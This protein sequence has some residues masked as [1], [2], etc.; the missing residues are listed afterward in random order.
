VKL[1]F[2][3][4]PEFAVPSLEALLG[5]GHQILAV[6]TQP[7]RPAGRGRKLTPSAVKQCALRHGLTLRQPQKMH[8]EDQAFRAD[9]PDALIVIAYGILLPTS[10]LAIPRLGGINVHTS[11]LPR[12]RGAA[13]IARAIEAGDAE[14]GVC[15][16]QMEAG[17]DTGP[18][19]AETRTAISDTDTAHSLHDRLAVLGAETLIQTLDQLLQGR[20]TPR[21]QNS[22]LASYAKKLHKNESF[23]DWR[24]PA[25]EL[26]RKIRALNPWPIASTHWRGKILR[27]WEVGGLHNNHYPDPPGTVLQADASGIHVQTGSGTITVTRLQIEGGKI[28][29]AADFL[30]GYSV[31]RGDQ[32]GTGG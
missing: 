14:T 9:S 20:V 4:T 21:Q 10:V 5:A 24:R 25:I 12:W 31:A 22:E 23:V 16:M 15:I 32:F 27:L 2:A 30:N 11:L 17:L 19:L 29:T 3:G 1:V 8:Q 13:P 28:L 7:D 26:H 18:V 6:Y